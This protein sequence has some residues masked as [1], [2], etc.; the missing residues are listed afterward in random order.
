MRIDYRVHSVAPVKVERDIELEG[1]KTKAVSDGIVVE[2]VPVVDTGRGTIT[3][4]VT[5]HTLGDEAGLF[6]AGDL[7]HVD[8][9]KGGK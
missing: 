4:Q 8:F 1:E 2:L 9:T 5:N 7:I 6:K 3:V